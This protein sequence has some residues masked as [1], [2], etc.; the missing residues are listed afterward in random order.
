MISFQEEKVVKQE[1]KKEEVKKE[2][3]P[4]KKIE[5]PKPIATTPTPQSKSGKAP[6]G[7]T[8]TRTEVRVPMSRMRIKIGGRLKEA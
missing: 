3:A 1:V 2:E 5:T 6:T 4:P 7:I 8:G